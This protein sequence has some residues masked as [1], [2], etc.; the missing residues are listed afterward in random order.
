[1]NEQQLNYL[2]LVTR[3]QAAIYGYIRS[4]AP[5]ADIEDILQETNLV[6]WEKAAVFEPGT[7]FKAYAFRIAHFKTLEALRG[8]RRRHWLVFD[9][10]LLEAIAARQTEADV[11][12]DGRQAALRKCLE[13]L[14]AEERELVHAR[15]SKGRSVRE[16]AREQERTEGSLQQWFFRIRNTLRACIERRI[17]PEGGGA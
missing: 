13:E 8:E 16:L 15:Y 7:N 2:Q 14:K 12:M 3:H 6:L 4:L 11:L 9:S 5:G 17:S 10:E 1:M